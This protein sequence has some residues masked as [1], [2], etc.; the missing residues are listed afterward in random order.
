[1]TKWLI[2]NGTIVDPTGKHGGGRDLL[3][4]DGKI[5]KIAARLTANGARVIDA[6]G[7]MILPGL[8][9]MHTHLRD[10]GQ[11]EKETIASGSRAAA[12]GGFTTICCMANTT[13]PLDDP[14]LIAYIVGKAEKEA[15]VNVLPVA[16]A[17]K[18]LKG[19]EIA[20]MGR[21][22]AA[23]AVAFSDD[24]QT[25]GRSDVMRRAIEYAKQFNKPIIAHCEDTNLSRGGAMNESQLST[26]IGLPGIPALAEEVVVA[27]DLLLA[28]K[29]GRVHIA[30]VSSAGSVR[31]VRQAKKDGA[32]VTCETAPHYFSLTEESVRNY[33]A[34]AKVS[35]PLRSEKD[36]KEIIR[37]LK[38]GTIDAIA[39][40]HAPHTLEEKKIEFSQ[41]ANGLIGLETALALAL[42]KLLP[43]GLTV[44]DVVK[45]M[46]TNPAG[47]L[48]LTGKGKLEAGADADIIIV[49]P[50]AEWTVD[51]EKFVSISRNTPFAGARLKGKVLYTI[52]SGKLVVKD[53]KLV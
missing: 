47:I 9:D 6:K 21:C 51:P 26:E 37:G 43:E 50:K 30:H 11:P 13:P 34:N 14:A 3:I 48:G 40:D 15:V 31:L 49:D 53:G 32:P 18:G 52:V 29:Y 45:L 44:K 8:I 38:D 2:K 7:L 22:V 12:L 39:T 5:T 10:P 23:G 33:D 41:A 28:K 42:T 27:R 20:E 16:A 24:G 46:A 1:M 25:I 36:R 4:E 17:T 35:P 19:E